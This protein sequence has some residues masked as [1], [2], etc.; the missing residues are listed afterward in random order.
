MQFRQDFQDFC[1][2]GNTLTPPA[3]NAGFWGQRVLR[4]SRIQ[5]F[6]GSVPG[7]Q[8][9]NAGC[10]FRSVTAALILN[11]TYRNYRAFR[12]YYISNWKTFKLVS[13]SA[14]VT[15]INSEKK[16]RSVSVT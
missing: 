3:N 11:S 15:V 5:G 13:L 10:V 8:A 1:Y 16:L 7:P 2:V 4:I 9:R 12:N 14:S 6:L